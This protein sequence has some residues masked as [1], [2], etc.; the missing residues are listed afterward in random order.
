MIVRP[1]FRRFLTGRP[2]DVKDCGGEHLPRDKRSKVD[3]PS[4]FEARFAR[5][6]PKIHYLSPLVYLGFILANCCQPCNA[7]EE[8]EIPKN[9]TKADLA[10]RMLAFPVTNSWYSCTSLGQ[11]Y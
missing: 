10:Y 6:V 7:V 3:R 11:G 5:A 9:I 8:G 4:V 1:R 2:F